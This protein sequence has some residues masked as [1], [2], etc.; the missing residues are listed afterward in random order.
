VSL[1]LYKARTAAP[2]TFEREAANETTLEVYLGGS[3][4]APTSPGVFTLKDAGG[5]VVSTS[6]PPIVS[7]ISVAAIPAVDLTNT[8]GFGERFRE[9]WVLPMPDGLT[10]TFTRE[11]AVAGFHLYPPSA[12]PD[13][14]ATYPGLLTE[15]GDAVAS[16]DPFLDKAWAVVLR[17]LWSHG[18]W[19]NLIVSNSQLVEP[20]EEQALYLIYRALSRSPG[21]RWAELRQEHKDAYSAAWGR[22]TFKID[23]DNDGLADSDDRRGRGTLV[24]RNAAPRRQ[25]PRDPRF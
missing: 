21:D 10:H 23:R 18:L 11:A 16:L 13:L 9:F 6:T 5:N 14:L 8:V 15:F 2:D 12:Q 19:P 3:L 25:R 22:A 20:L 24:H 17:S 4:V 7:D 1:Q